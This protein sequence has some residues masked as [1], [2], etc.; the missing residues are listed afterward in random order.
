M[1]PATKPDPGPFAGLE[2]LRIWAARAEGDKAPL[3]TDGRRASTTD[4]STWATRSA[5]EEASRKRGA[6]AGVMLGKLP[7]G[8]HLCG[9]DLDGA[10]EGPGEPWAPWADETLSR[11]DSAAERSLSGRGAHIFFTLAETDAHRLRKDGL[12]ETAGREFSIGNHTGIA[13]YTGS[14]FLAVTEDWINAEPIKR[15]DYEAVREFL[16]EYCPAFK[17]EYGGRKAIGKLSGSEHGFRFFCDQFMV[18]ANDNEAVEAIANDD[19]PAGE[20]WQRAGD[21]QQRRTVKNAKARIEKEEQELIDG[22]E[23]LENLAQK[24]R[25][26]IAELNKRHAFVAMPKAAVVTLK[27]EGIEFATP[28]D[29]RSTYQNRFF[30]KRN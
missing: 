30:G 2:D 23:N 17:A 22:F 20:W 7:N 1:T 27:P 8:L 4:R 9:I 24:F 3:Q 13:L 11:F 15:M 21:H 5:A 25:R 28:A 14:K 12:I 6:Q 18:G 29:F 10:A 16:E 26:Q 19:G